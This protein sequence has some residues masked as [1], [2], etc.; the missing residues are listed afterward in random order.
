MKKIKT[1]LI[2]I[3]I[4][5][6][7][8]QIAHVVK[9]KKEE[10]LN[11][12]NEFVEYRNSDYIECKNKNHDIENCNVMKRI[13]HVFKYYNEHKAFKRIQIC[14]FLL[15]LKN[16][17][18]PRFM[19]D[20][21]QLKINHLNDNDDETLEVIQNNTHI[22]CDD[23][24]KCDHIRRYQRNRGNDVNISTDYKNVIL[25]DQLDSIHTY[26]F[27]SMRGSRKN[28][29]NTY[30]EKEFKSEVWSNNPQTIPE[31]NTEQIIW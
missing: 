6:S 27:H 1:M 19:E 18:I 14:E 12:S 5:P 15:S 16:Y 4:Y 17:D 21:Q 29:D 9:S 13:L 7:T 23:K 31:C 2:Q 10:K 20:W 26:I 25:I 24:R 3:H 11:G 8:M 22:S 30:D 28:D